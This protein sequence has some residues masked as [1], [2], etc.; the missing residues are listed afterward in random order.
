[1]HGV[2]TTPGAH[3]N[4]PLACLPVTLL[5]VPWVLLWEGAEEGDAS[6]AP[7]SP[8]PGLGLLLLTATTGGGLDTASELGDTPG[9][10]D[11]STAP[12]SPRL[13]LGLLLLTASAAPGEGLG[14]AAVLGE[15][16]GEGDWGA[17][18]GD[19]ATAPT[20]PKP[21]LGLLLLTATTG[22]GLDTASVLGDS[23]S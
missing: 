18:E 6:T 3:P 13:G 22:E 21:G 14:A 17:G 20:S 16:S 10:G 11:V 9:E 23:P 8:R 15:A 4:A 7:T 5:V 1:M 2:V 12:S 19:A